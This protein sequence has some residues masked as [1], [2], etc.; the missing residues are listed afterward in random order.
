MTKID[1]GTMK[2]SLLFRLLFFPTL[3][4]F[5]FNSLLNLADGIFVGRGVG[6]DALAAVNIV[7]PIFLISVGIGLMFGIGASVKGGIYLAQHRFRQ[8]CISMTQAF[9]TAFAIMGLIAC[10]CLIFPETTLNMLGCTD[11]LHHYAADYLLYIA[12]GCMFL[13]LQVVGMML[14]RLDGSPK[15]AMMCN[16]IPATCNIILDYV[17]VFPLDMG[18]AG[19]AIAT[20]ICCVLGGMMAVLYFLRFS[21]NLK[22]C[23]IKLSADGIRSWIRNSLGQ[24]KLGISAFLGEVSIAAMMLTGNYIFMERLGE[25]GVAAFGVSCYLFPLIFMINNAVAQSAQPIMSYN[26]GACRFDRVKSALKVSV[27]AGVLGGVTA[28]AALWLFGPQ[29]VSM[30]LDTNCTAYTIAADGIKFFGLCAIFFAANIAFIGFFQSIEQAWRATI[31]TLMR[32]II[33]LIPA[34]LLLPGILGTAGIWFAIPAAE[35]LTMT[36]I[37]IS[38]LTNRKSFFNTGDNRQ[39]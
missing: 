37:T 24:M 9:I 17:F 26:Y 4:G 28:S 1:Y 32:G 15:Y 12:P 11:R 2:I 29:I 34:F 21:N 22:F 14:I 30:F 3:L 16:I 10:I 5:I 39:L 35:F 36:I 38:Y 13:M 31:Y 33:F 23:R 20:S 7:A 18:I 6:S 19:A 25:D 27:S 8:S